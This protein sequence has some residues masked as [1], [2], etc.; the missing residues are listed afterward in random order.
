MSG[1]KFV[2][3]GRAIKKITNEDLGYDL[4]LNAFGL[5][6]QTAQTMLSEGLADETLE[7]WLKDVLQSA[8]K[9]GKRIIKKS[10]LENVLGEVSFVSKLTLT[11]DDPSDTESTDDPSLTDISNIMSSE[12][13]EVDI[14]QSQSILEPERG[15]VRELEEEIER[16]KKIIQ[17]IL[18]KQAELA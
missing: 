10:D 14:K 18:N 3:S 4:S 1:H 6:N 9:S 11:A 2:L 5:L 7:T 12:W 16:L 15:L 17:I 13:R 8:G